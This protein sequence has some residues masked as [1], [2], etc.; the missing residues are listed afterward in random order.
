MSDTC[1][2]RGLIRGLWMFGVSGPHAESEAMHYARQYLS[3]G[4]VE[5]QRKVGK[6]WKT[7]ATMSTA[8]HEKDN[9]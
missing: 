9:A 2:Y 4:P 5:V 7:V 1:D 6:R 3:E 8:Q